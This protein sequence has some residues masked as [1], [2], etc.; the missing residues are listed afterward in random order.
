MSHKFILIVAATIFAGI[1]ASGQTGGQPAT[2]TG[3]FGGAIV[4]TPTATLPTPAPAAG[5]SDAGRAGISATAPMSAG[6]QSSL[7][8][9]TVVYTTGAPANPSEANLSKA[10]NTQGSVMN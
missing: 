8:N 10:A 5:I 1:S 4:T 6:V 9:S 7:E 2:N 3:P